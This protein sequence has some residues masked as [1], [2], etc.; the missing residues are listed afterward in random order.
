MRS[1][2]LLRRRERE[3]LVAR[4]V[5]DR[6]VLGVGGHLVERL[7]VRGKMDV[8]FRAHPFEQALEVV[9]RARPVLVVGGADLGD[10]HGRLRRVLLSCRFWNTAGRGRG[11]VPSDEET[12]AGGGLGISSAGGGGGAGF[13]RRT[14]EPRLGSTAASRAMRRERKPVSE[15]L[16]GEGQNCDAEREGVSMGERVEQAR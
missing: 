10:E 12:C 2:G 5:E 11:A 3:R 13:A 1:R 14:A 16:R 9:G 7:D 6:R 4:T 8:H 15:F